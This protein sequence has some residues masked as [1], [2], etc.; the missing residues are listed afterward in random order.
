MDCGMSRAAEHHA[1]FDDARIEAAGTLAEMQRTRRAADGA[2]LELALLDAAMDDPIGS[3]IGKQ[4][5]AWERDFAER[6]WLVT[7]HAVQGGEDVQQY[8]MLRMVGVLKDVM[9]RSGFKEMFVAEGVERAKHGPLTP[10]NV[11][12]GQGVA[13]AATAAARGQLAR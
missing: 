3:L 12:L 4:T 8:D 11:E 10:V 6:G 5:E 1:R 7:M 9:I 13:D 2:M